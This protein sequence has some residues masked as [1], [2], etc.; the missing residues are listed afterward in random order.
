[1]FTSMLGV[2][3]DHALT[4]CDEFRIVLAFRL[5]KKVLKS[6]SS[7]VDGSTGRDSVAIVRR[8]DLH[9]HYQK[10]IRRYDTENQK[11]NDD[12]DYLFLPDMGV[13][14]A[15]THRWQS[16]A[17]CLVGETMIA[18]SNGQHA[19]IDQLYTNGVYDKSTISYDN[20]NDKF[21]EKEISQVLL[22]K[23]VDELVEVVLENGE[24]VVCTP[25]HRFL[26]KNGQYIE[27]QCITDSTDLMDV[28]YQAWKNSYKSEIED[29]E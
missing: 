19:R 20:V 3:I 6:M 2:S 4:Y 11:L 28:P 15:A 8:S 17:H 22:S 23:Y 9:K 18:L 12:E 14:T 27:A 1:M 5:F 29:A 21:I 7:Y 24:T 10:R 16:G 25:N 13:A 26:M